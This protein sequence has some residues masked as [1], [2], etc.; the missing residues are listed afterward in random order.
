MAVSLPDANTDAGTLA[1]LMLN[2]IRSPLFREYNADEAHTAL[3]AVKACVDNRLHYKPSSTFYVR[4]GA[5]SY[6][7]VIVAGA[8][9]HTQYHGFSGSKGNVIIA[10][11]VQK[12]INKFWRLQILE[13]R[14]E[15][16]I[17]SSWSS[18][19]SMIL[20]AIPLQ[21]SVRAH[22]AGAQ[23]MLELLKEDC[24]KKNL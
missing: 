4:A 3:R 21:V 1:R 6:M 11:D 16:P 8:P 23:S 12:K 15:W 13:R 2:E 19:S 20:S 10:N 7:D 9:A 22:M 18:K 5:D 24:G 17:L 14:G